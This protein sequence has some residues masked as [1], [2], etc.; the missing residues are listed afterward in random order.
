MQAQDLPDGSRIKQCQECQNTKDASEFHTEARNP[1]KLS[2]KCKE[3]RKMGLKQVNMVLSLPEV[4]R[5]LE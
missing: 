1:D 5:R 2:H 4:R 3:C